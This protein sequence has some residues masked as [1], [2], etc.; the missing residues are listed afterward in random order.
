M[1]PSP[2]EHLDVVI[3][4][5]SFIGEVGAEFWLGFVFCNY[6]LGGDFS[7]AHSSVGTWDFYIFFPLT[8]IVIFIKL[9]TQSERNFYQPHMTYKRDEKCKCL[10]FS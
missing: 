7:T 6:I 10:F 1:L 5:F 3:N 9:P 8:N 4:L 2:Q